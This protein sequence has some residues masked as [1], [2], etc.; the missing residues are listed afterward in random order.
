M[1]EVL[2]TLEKARVRTEFLVVKAT[3]L[4]Q[5]CFLSGCAHCCLRWLLTSA[6]GSRWESGGCCRPPCCFLTSFPSLCSCTAAQSTLPSLPSSSSWLLLTFLF[7]LF[8]YCSLASALVYC[9]CFS[10]LLWS[11][12]SRTSF[13]TQGWIVR[14]NTINVIIVKLCMMALLI[15]LYLFIALSVTLTIFQGHSNVEQL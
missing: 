5:L 14:L 8:L 6:V 10:C 12:R 9:C 1:R 4:V 3:S 11:H 2:V 15:E 13:V 7:L